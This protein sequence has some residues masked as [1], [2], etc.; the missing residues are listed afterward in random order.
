MSKK[1]KEKKCTN[2]CFTY[3]TFSSSIQVSISVSLINN[4]AKRKKADET[5]KQITKRNKEKTR[6]KKKGGG[7]KGEKGKEIAKSFDIIVS[8]Y[9]PF[10]LLKINKIDKFFLYY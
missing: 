1:K 8:F 2:C 4:Y 3:S 9:F 10:F 7:K 6:E 5:E